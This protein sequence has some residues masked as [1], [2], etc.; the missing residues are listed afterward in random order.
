MLRA[1]GTKWQ[2]PGPTLV[3]LIL[4]YIN[5]TSQ[6]TFP[7]WSSVT[8]LLTAMAPPVSWSWDRCLLAA[9]LQSSAR[10]IPSPWPCSRSP[11]SG[12][13]ELG[14]LHTH[15][16]QLSTDV[17]DF[18]WNTNSLGGQNELTFTKFSNF[19]GGKEEIS[20]ID[21]VFSHERAMVRNTIEHNALGV[22]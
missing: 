15:G 21:G 14:S 9:S 13:A 5:H 18:L 11:R 12:S 7:L 6:I 8:Y 22:F 20:D 16:Q 10:W 17:D 1:T 4:P 2:L 19:Y 3:L